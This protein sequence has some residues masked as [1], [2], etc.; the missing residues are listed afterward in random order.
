MIIKESLFLLVKISNRVCH[1]WLGDNSKPTLQ[2]W[3]WRLSH[4][5]ILPASSVGLIFT[6]STK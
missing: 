2:Y 1:E 3:Y 6:Q 4:S 5:D